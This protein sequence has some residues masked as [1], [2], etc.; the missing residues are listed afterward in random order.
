MMEDAHLEGEHEELAHIGAVLR[1][2]Y[3]RLLDLSIASV[4]KDLGDTK[5]LS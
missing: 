4:A 5:I 2:L 3:L 1:D